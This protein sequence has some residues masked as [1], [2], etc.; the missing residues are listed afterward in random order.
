MQESVVREAEHYHRWFGINQE[1]AQKVVQVQQK[2]PW[3][4]AE[5]D[6][7]ILEVYRVAISKV[8]T[9]LGVVSDPEILG[10]E[11]VIAGTRVPVELILSELAAGRTPA[12]ILHS[13][14]S[15]PL[16]AIDTVITYVQ[17]LPAEHPLAQLFSK[18]REI[19]G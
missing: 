16:G 19:C 4:R 9:K 12:E 5:A 14:P 15:L 13:Y 17:S 1:M 10:G 8:M 2:D 3:E 6:W 7:Q 11:P 18:S